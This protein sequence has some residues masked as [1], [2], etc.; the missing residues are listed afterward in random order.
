VLVRGTPFREIG[1]RTLRPEDCPGATVASDP[2][3]A[4]ALTDWVIRV[5]SVIVFGGILYV[6]SAKIRRAHLTD[7]RSVPS[8]Y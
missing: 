3:A 2:A 5:L 4:V 8:A 1:A 6:F 7:R